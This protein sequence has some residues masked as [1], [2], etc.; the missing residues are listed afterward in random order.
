M[1][2]KNYVGGVSVEGS[3]GEIAVSAI[4]QLESKVDINAEINEE[5]LCQLRKRV[6]KI[7]EA[8]VMTGTVGDLCFTPYEE[9]P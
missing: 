1:A 8:L 9:E 5:F 7:E 6:R 2:E 3:L 4:K